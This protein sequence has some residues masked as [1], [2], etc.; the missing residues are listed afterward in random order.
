LQ[1]YFDAEKTQKVV[2]KPKRKHA[3]YLHRRLHFLLLA[4]MIVVWWATNQ[5]L[6]T[7]Y[8][9]IWLAPPYT[10]L[11]SYVYLLISLVWIPFAIRHIRHLGW[12]WLTAV[13]IAGCLISTF[14]ITTIIM[15]FRYQDCLSYEEGSV[16]CT[17][18]CSWH[19][20]AYTYEV[21]DH[22]PL[23]YLVDR[24]DWIEQLS[25]LRR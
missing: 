16:I 4:W 1:P 20:F 3:P 23:M 6:P 22:L 11:T 9:L 15:P 18:L 2:D 12:H 10:D 24:K 17:N 8:P 19:S 21:I 14:H 25:C 7:L 5:F 13:L